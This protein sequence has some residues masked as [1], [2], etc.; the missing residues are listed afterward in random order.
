MSHTLLPESPGVYVLKLA[1]VVVY[2]GQ[3]GNVR[4]RIATHHV[5]EFDTV[6]VIACPAEELRRLEK[7]K[8]IELRP[9]RNLVFSPW[10]STTQPTC[11]ISF[12]DPSGLK[13]QLAAA[14]L[15]TGINRTELILA[16]IR[17]AYATNGASLIPDPTTP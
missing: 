9:T 5:T 10:N 1:G 16:C 13:K 15:C 4:K 3:S 6:E 2:V 8:I 17:M 11:M 7:E 12:R 14:A